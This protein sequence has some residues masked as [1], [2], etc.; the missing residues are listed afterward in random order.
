MPFAVYDFMP[1]LLG[2]MR[3]PIPNTVEAT[4]YSKL[5]LGKKTQRPSSA[6]IASYGN[7]ARLLAVGQKPSQWALQ[8]EEIR[9]KGIDWRTVGYRGLRTKR[10][11]YVVNRGPEGKNLK[12]LLYDNAKDPYQLNPVETTY[13]NENP[14]MAKLDSQ[15]QQWLD[16]MNDPFPLR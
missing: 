4:D 15:L 1:T 3:L 12:R 16:K 11:T 6:F 5:M 10:Y 14:I 8:A 13:A 9:K 7:P 2:L